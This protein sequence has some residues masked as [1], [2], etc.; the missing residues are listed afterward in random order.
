[1]YSNHF[2]GRILPQQKP[3]QNSLHR[4][5]IWP[6]MAGY[7]LGGRFGIGGVDPLDDHR[8]RQHCPPWSPKCTI[9]YL[10]S[11]GVL[12]LTEG[13]FKKQKQSFQIV[14]AQVG[15][16]FNMAKLNFKIQL[17]VTK[18]IWDDLPQ[19]LQLRIEKEVSGVFRSETSPCLSPILW[20]PLTA[21][22]KQLQ[23]KSLPK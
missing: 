7:F 18:G 9:T 23:K 6:T 13:S 17:F 22:Q 8:P 19:T 21:E 15:H 2:V 1:M 5:R 4:N 20:N 3:A 11:D 12:T 10:S 16:I 14:H